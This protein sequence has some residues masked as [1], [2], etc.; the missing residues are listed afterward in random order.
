MSLVPGGGQVLTSPAQG[1]PA[2][3]GPAQ[4][5]SGNRSPADLSPTDLSP[6][7]L[8]PAD[9]SLGDRSLANRRP[10]PSLRGR[11][12]GACHAFTLPGASDAPGRRAWS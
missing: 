8:N 6:A 9:R 1:G 7:D 10:A 5:S 4:G 12:D 2:Q 3:G 11:R